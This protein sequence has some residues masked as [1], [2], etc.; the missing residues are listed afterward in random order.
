MYRNLLYGFV[1]LASITACDDGRIEEGQHEFSTEKGWVVKLTGQLRGVS[2]WGN[3]YSLAVAGFNETSSYAVISKTIPIN[4]PDGVA[5]EWTMSGVNE[6]V[7]IIK[8]CAIDKLRRSVADFVVLTRGDWDAATGDTIRMDLGT[9]DVSMFSA[10]Q[11]EVFNAK[12]VSCHGQSTFAGASLYLTEGKSYEALVN[13]ASKCQP[14]FLL[15]QPENPDNS[16]L[17]HVVTENGAV[18]HDHMDLFSEKDENQLELI[19]KWIENGA[20]E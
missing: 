5:M 11:K 8:L 9:L 10:I 20:Q 3:A 2:T 6:E 14:S 18:K 16:F 4:Q 19:K 12:C 17:Y 1:L 13:K 15:V 7:R